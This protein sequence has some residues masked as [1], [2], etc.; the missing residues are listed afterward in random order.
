MLKKQ[1]SNICKLRA[2]A[3][4]IFLGLAA[5]AVS[6][7][8]AQTY[9]VL[10]TF[11]NLPDGANPYPLIQDA[12]GNL[13]GTTEWGGVICGSGTDC[14]T[15]YKVDSAGTE[16]VLHRFTGAG[17]GA[18]PVSALVRDA[19]GNLYGTTR[20]NGSIPA[21]S[22]I[23]KVD[24]KGNE[25][26]LYVFDR[27]F[28]ACCQDSSLAIDETNN[29]YGMS[30]YGG[31]F[32]CGSNQLGCGLLYKLTRGRKFKLLHT[33][34]GPDGIQPEG[35]LVRDAKGNLYGTTYL[36]ASLLAVLLAA[37]PYSS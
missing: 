22:T 2:V 6:P 32:N 3:V 10:H 24:T 18:N 16:T 8:H 15:V 14:G 11:T 19:A 13:Y 27:G 34:K 17:D 23:F 5:I 26:V 4:M 33:F 7:A 31:D 37:G 12:Q 9:T 21:F 36:G 29:L 1:F 20:G 30:P 28:Q 25:S 35:G